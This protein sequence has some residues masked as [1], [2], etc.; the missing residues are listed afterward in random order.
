M[1]MD[2]VPEVGETVHPIM[3]GRGVFGGQVRKEDTVWSASDARA[4]PASS[5]EV[6]A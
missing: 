3:R 5:W 1:V 2:H 6:M 4:Y